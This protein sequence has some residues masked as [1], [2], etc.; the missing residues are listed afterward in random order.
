MKSFKTV[1]WR[2]R[3]ARTGFTLIELLVVI[4]IIAILAGM[5]L[6][7]LSRAKESGRRIA[8]LNNLRQLGLALNMYVDE[9]EGYL[10]P[11]VHPNRWPSRLYD[12]FKDLRILL[13]PSDAP[14]PATIP[15]NPTLWPAD[16]APRS[17]IMN[18]WNDFY[19]TK[20]GPAWRMDPMGIDI[21]MHE[22]MI[23][24]PSA[25]IFLAEKDY[26]SGHFYLDYERY[27]DITQL[28]Q[29]RHA[30]VSKKPG[31]GGSNYGFADGSA[32]FLRFGQAVNPINMLAV[33]PEW[34]NVG[35]P[36]Q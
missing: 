36:T 29:S 18:A 25:T 8:C 13:C 31:S 23:H 33:M 27:E 1:S 32:R 5:L 34:R 15:T 19:R 7:A 35:T 24:E 28:D 22:A 30:T 16:A 10:P 11:R 21:G 9:N 26:N 3:S 12:G 17:Y 4:A 20:F 2:L 14:N 6:P